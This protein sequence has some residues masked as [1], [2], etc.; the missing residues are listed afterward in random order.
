MIFHQIFFLN[1]LES[2]QAVHCGS[3]SG[4]RNEIALHQ[5]WFNWIF[6]NFIQNS[7]VKTPL[8]S[9]FIAIALT[10]TIYSYA[11]HFKIVTNKRI[12]KRT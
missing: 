5:D 3:S 1:S 4:P 9:N 7:C 8:E 6:Q 12:L 10:C 2:H 11:L